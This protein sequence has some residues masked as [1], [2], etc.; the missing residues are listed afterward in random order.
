MADNAFGAREQW[1]K[2]HVQRMTA[3]AK[4]KTAHNA[5]LEANK[6]FTD[7]QNGF[8]N[9]CSG[10][11]CIYRVYLCA[12]LGLLIRADADCSSKWQQY[13]M[14]DRRHAV[15]LENESLAALNLLLAKCIETLSLFD[16]LANSEFAAI[17]RTDPSTPTPMH[18]TQSLI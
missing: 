18:Q 17:V 8:A 10:C 6:R 9:A 2:L 14:F 1:E 3:L 7:E 12:R 16:I 15:A 13:L 5:A 11:V 4:P